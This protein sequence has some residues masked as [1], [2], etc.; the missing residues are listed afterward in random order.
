MDLG[1]ELGDFALNTFIKPQI[2]TAIVNWTAQDKTKTP[3]QQAEM[4]SEIE[5]GV[6]A[7]LQIGLEE[8]MTSKKPS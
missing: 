4:A 3:E 8:Y 1:A 5:V 2:H 7:A 6:M